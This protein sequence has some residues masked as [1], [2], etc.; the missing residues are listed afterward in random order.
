MT[1]FSLTRSSS[2]WAPRVRTTQSVTSDPLLMTPLTRTAP[3]RRSREKP[4]WQS[5]SPLL[6]C[7]QAGRRLAW[8]PRGSA[9]V[10]D[11]SNAL[12]NLI[13]SLLS[14]QEAAQ[15]FYDDPQG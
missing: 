12:L 8:T 4:R 14:D 10:L 15:D 11:S 13:L 2:A 1:P 7:N 3:N 9:V 5:R 6:A